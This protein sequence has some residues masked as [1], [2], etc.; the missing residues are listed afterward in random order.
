MSLLAC[1]HDMCAYG[2]ILS[3]SGALIPFLP[4]PQHFKFRSLKGF[5]RRLEE[6][7]LDFLIIQVGRS[8]LYEGYANIDV[9]SGEQLLKVT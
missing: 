5:W 1:L 8:S 4:F 7:D 2:L 3:T 6:E 9:T